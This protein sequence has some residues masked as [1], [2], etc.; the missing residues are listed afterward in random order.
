[1]SLAKS[2]DGADSRNGE[3]RAHLAIKKAIISN[4][5]APGEFLA[6]QKLADL[7]QVSRTPIREAL[8]RLGQEGLVEIVP[9]RGVFV[10]RIS[11]EDAIEIFNMREAL[12]G[13][14]ARCAAL[15][16]NTE[17][18]DQLERSLDESALLSGKERLLSMY[19][20]GG[21]IHEAAL[22]ASG[23]RRLRETV[24]HLNDQITRL[25]ILSTTADSRIEESC[26]EH[27]AILAALRKRDPDGSERAMRAHVASTFRTV[28]EIMTTKPVLHGSLPLPGS[29]GRALAFV[30]KEPDEG[31]S[32]SNR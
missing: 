22:I 9:G 6:A 14:A 5:F 18:L 25:R 19:A 2:G 31:W 17:T 16:M 3:R 4:Q 24:I 21:A 12:E 7:Y 23:S 11:L 32:P 10:A 15:R 29:E 8:Q 1:M 30:S 20:A 26:K 27:Y 28:L 13:M